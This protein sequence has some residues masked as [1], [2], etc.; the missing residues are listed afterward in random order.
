MLKYNSDQHR[1]YMHLTRKIG[2][3]WVEIFEGNSTFYSTDYWDL[4]TEMWYF[5]KPMMVSDALKFMKSIKSP[6]TAR[7][8]LQKVI[9]SGI[10]IE[11]KNPEDER[12]M[13]VSLSPEI[14]GKL[15]VFFDKTVDS[16][17]IFVTRIEDKA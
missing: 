11:T 1:E 16:M 14:R 6:F 7:K 13:L 3:D 9:D 15:D 12:S 2:A 8:Y 5:D 10:V 4:L 17:K